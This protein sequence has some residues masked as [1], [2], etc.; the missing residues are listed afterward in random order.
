MPKL[1]TAQDV[2]KARKQAVVAL[3]QARTPFY[4]M[5]GAGD[6]ASEAVRDYV[7]KARSEAGGPAK[8]SQTRLNE[9][10]S[11]LNELQ[12]R[13]VE[14]RAQVRTKVNELPELRDRLDSAEL[15]HALEN[16]VQ[17][18]QELYE[19]LAVRGQLRFDQFRQQPQVQ[20]AVHQVE[21]AADTTEERVGKFVEDARELTYDVLGRVSRMTRS[22][23]ES[24]ADRT[25]KLADEVAEAIEETGDKVASTTRSAGDEVASTTREAASSTRSAGDEVASTTRKV[26]NRTQPSRSSTRTAS[27]TTIRRNT[28]P[29]K[30]GTTA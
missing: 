15:R 22:T 12:G 25:E 8:D 3:E 24:A 5:L 16:Y 19:R 4:A 10:Q 29:R 30:G 14:V 2:R 20:R 18:L 23:G 28:T 21:G 7:M 27:T 17:S 6:L 11:K 13:L 1:P 9:L 26:A